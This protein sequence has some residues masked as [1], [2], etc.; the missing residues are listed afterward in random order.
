MPLDI[1]DFTRLAA[2]TIISTRDL[3]VSGQGKSA[4]AKLGNFIF[5]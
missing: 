1:S 5:S 3:V 4:K 2:S